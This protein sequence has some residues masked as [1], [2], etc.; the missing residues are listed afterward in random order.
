MTIPPRVR[1][2]VV[3]SF[4]DEE[5][6]VALAEKLHKCPFQFLQ[7]KRALVSFFSRIEF[8]VST[9]LLSKKLSI[10]DSLK[11]GLGG[12]VLLMD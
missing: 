10:T 6:A 5:A 8:C 2:Y 4:L 12:M 9:V 11:A 7:E 1:E 3:E